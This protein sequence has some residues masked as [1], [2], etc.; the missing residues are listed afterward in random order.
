MFVTELMY[1]KWDER[2]PFPSY[3]T[4]AERM[5]ISIPYARSTARA[6]ERKGYLV[7]IVRIG[8][9]N[10]FDLQPLFDAVARRVAEESAAA[11]AEKKAA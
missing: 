8:R 2:K 7:R 9:P 5:G 11:S 6:L 4:I 1:H 10:E 3:K